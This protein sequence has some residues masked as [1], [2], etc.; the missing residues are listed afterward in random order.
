ML[1]K[2]SQSQNDRQILILYQ[3]LWKDIH[4]FVKPESVATV[5]WLY[6]VSYDDQL[7]T[8]RIQM[9]RSLQC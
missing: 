4:T 5:L 7:G 2:I 8:K 3:V 6:A 1:I 9:I